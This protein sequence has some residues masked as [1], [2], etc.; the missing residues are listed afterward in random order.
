MSD[1]A[2]KTSTSFTL[3]M[4]MIGASLL[5]ASFI[6]FRLGAVFSFI[7]LTFTIVVVLFLMR[8]FLEAVYYT[9]CG[10]YRELA[11]KILGRGFS[12]LLDF[13]IDI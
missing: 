7:L 3:L 5:S 8:F 1:L 4:S 2:L 12:L 11:E 9:G 13:A 10:T 6:I